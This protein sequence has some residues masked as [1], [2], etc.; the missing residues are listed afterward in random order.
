[1]AIGHSAASSTLQFDRAKV[2]VDDDEY[3]AL[4]VSVHEIPPWWPNLYHTRLLPRIV[5]QS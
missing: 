1:M 5:N 2:V 4:A 3:G